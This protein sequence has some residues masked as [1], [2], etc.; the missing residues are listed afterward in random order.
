M[1]PN[2]F[3]KGIMYRIIGSDG[4]EYGPLTAEQLRQYI[5]EGRV[6]GQTQVL[7][8]GQAQWTTLGQIAEFS[9]D[10]SA[11]APVTPTPMPAAPTP[12]PIPLSEPPVHPLA[13][14][15]LVLGILSFVGCCCCDGFP[16]SISGLIVSIIALVQ[17]KNDPYRR[18]GKGLA[19]A[20]LILSILGIVMG[21]GLVIFGFASKDKDWFKEL[22]NKWGH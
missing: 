15:G 7:V 10:L 21:L 13:I 22:Q 2:A 8:E 12:A 14:T 18:S 6:N 17:I 3:S 4:K 1:R 20:G 5:A 9:A 19:M 16:F 11:H